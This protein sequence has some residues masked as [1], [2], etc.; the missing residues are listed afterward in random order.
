MCKISIRGR[1]PAQNIVYGYKSLVWNS[2]ILATYL[3]YGNFLK[4][5]LLT[6]GLSVA[7]VKFVAN[8]LL[9]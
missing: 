5:K 6:Y 3:I 2:R 1:F 9:F 8:V 7:Q 4:G